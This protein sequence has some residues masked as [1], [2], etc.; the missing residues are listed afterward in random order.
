MAD[1]LR[2]VCI[3]GRKLEVAHNFE[4]MWGGW[5]LY[6]VHKQFEGFIRKLEVVHK[7]VGVCLISYNLQLACVRK[8][9]ALV[10]SIALNGTMV[11]NHWLGS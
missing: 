9:R 6:N 10:A 1:N 7:Q 5:R 8:K 2:L 11:I 3:F 4:V